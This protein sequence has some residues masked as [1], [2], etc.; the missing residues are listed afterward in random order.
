MARR[1]N[2]AARRLLFQYVRRRARMTACS[3]QAGSRSACGPRRRSRSASR[4]SAAYHRRQRCRLARLAPR[5]RAAAMPSS[6]AVRTQ[7]I[8][9]AGWP[10]PRRSGGRVAGRHSWRGRGTRDPPGIDGAVDDDGDRSV[11]QACGHARHTLN[12]MS[13]QPRELHLVRISR[14]DGAIG[15]LRGD[16]GCNGGVF[17]G[18]SAPWLVFGREPDHGD[19]T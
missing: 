6:S 12:P 10:D 18:A 3:T 1:R 5:A 15:S 11:C 4:P 19:A 16:S 8:L 14:D 2:S 7:R 13:H 17:Q 9:N